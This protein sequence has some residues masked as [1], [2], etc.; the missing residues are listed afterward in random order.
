VLD[1]EGLVTDASLPNLA[2]NSSK[3]IEYNDSLQLLPLSIMLSAGPYTSCDDLDY[4]ALRDLLNQVKAKQPDVLIL[5]G[6]F[7]EQEHKAINNLK[8]SAGE[9]FLNILTDI[10][11]S[12]RAL[13]TKLIIVPSPRDVPHV[14]IFPQPQYSLNGEFS[15]ELASGK[16]IL[17]NNPA[18]IRINDFSIGIANIELLANFPELSSITN[19]DNKLPRLARLS[20]HCIEQ[21]S[22]F[23]LFPAP[24]AAAE[25]NI[26][27]SKM[28][29][30]AM[31]Y[32]PDILITP[33][34]TKHFIQATE[35]CLLINPESLIRN[36]KDPGYYCHLSI[37][38]LDDNELDNIINNNHNQHRITQHYITKRTRA[39]IIRI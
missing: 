23:P 31:P 18:T 13:K 11:S 10:L 6:P 34:K 27:Y 5:L 8:D 38:P 15:A 32:T 35:K 17:A 9:L 7:I 20:N 39:D 16:L 19:G 1:D 29:R 24:P 2:L 36:K 22:Y 30:Y 21:Q 14:P 26:D 3:I 12:I 4:L 37:H 33:S 28:N 25:L